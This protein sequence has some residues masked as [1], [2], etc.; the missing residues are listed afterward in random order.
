[1]SESMNRDNRQRAVLQWVSDTFG[2]PATAV[3]ERVLRVLEEA[4]EL[5]QAEGV[6]RDRARSVVDY[7]FSKP[8]GDPSQEVGGLGVTLL[9][10][11]EAS[12]LLADTEEQHEF[13]RVIAMDPTLFRAR[14]NKKADAGIAVRAA[15]PGDKR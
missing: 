14:H 4:V 11:C 1:M 8:P 5:A 2:E 6:T 7:V 9:A 10:Y 15:E 12:G 3:E 13:D